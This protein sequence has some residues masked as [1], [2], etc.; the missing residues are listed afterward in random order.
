MRY[1]SDSW[2]SDICLFYHISLHH[3]AKTVLSLTA[4][5]ISSNATSTFHIFP[6][7]PPC[8]NV[9]PPPI[10]AGTSRPRDT[11]RS[12]EMPATPRLH[13][14][15]PPPTASIPEVADWTL[16]LPI[17][18]LYS[19][20]AMAKFIVSVCATMSS[21]AAAMRRPKSRSDNVER[22]W[23]RESGGVNESMSPLTTGV[24]SVRSLTESDANGKIHSVKKAEGDFVV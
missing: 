7:N 22:R 19:S 1:V 8:P 14:R 11:R 16:C 12:H 4:A 10:P 15:T 20:Y 13:T 21:R 2:W 23:S 24:L 5:G 6:S 17:N 18:E 9:L 3:L